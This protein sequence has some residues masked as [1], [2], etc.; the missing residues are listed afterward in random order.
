MSTP[1]IAPWRASAEVDSTTTVGRRDDIDG[2]RALA[3]LL[4]VVY[5]VWLGRVSGGVDVFLMLSAFFLTL[6]FTRRL[7]SGNPLGI[8]R[9]WIR[10]FKRLL[11]A[12]VVV[13]VAVLA[14]TALLL[15]PT[16]WPT[17]WQQ[18]WTSLF[19]VQNWQLAAT[20]VDYYAPHGALVSP[21]QHFWSLSV[22]GQ[23]FILWPLI[24]VLAGA[25][26]R[27]SGRQVRTVLAVLFG[28]V[29]IVSLASSVAETA[30]AQ[31]FA[32]FDTGARLWEF[33][34]GSLV[35]L[36]L[37]FVNL[38][39][40]ARVA[41]GWGGI[42]A[43]FMCGLVLD[44]RGGFPGF[45]ALWP[46]LAC[47]AVVLGG[48]RPT[49]Y[50]P[51]RLL[52]SPPLR[53]LGTWSY[54]LYLVHWPV[55]IFWFAITGRNSAGLLSGMAII[56]V[57][58]CLAYLVH[59]L[60]EQPVR[61][62][63]WADVTPRRGVAVIVAAVLVVAVPLTYWQANE[64]QRA[65]E[66]S[67]IGDHP[68]AEVL[69]GGF[70][71]GFA[72]STPAVPLATALDAEWIALDGPCTGAFVPED[73]ELEGSCTQSIGAPSDA[74]TIVVV[75]DSHAEQ[76]MG[77]L[78]PITEEEEWQVVAL[79]KGGCP[80]AV[81]EGKC[82]VWS[83]A[84]LRY[85]VEL[86]PEAVFTIGTAAEI[87]GSGEQL[88]PGIMRVLDE[89]TDAGIDV[90]AVRDN[91]RYSVNRYECA[92]ANGPDHSAC[93]VAVSDALADPSPLDDVAW[94]S[95]VHPVDLTP[96]I[97]PDDVCIAVVGNVYVYLDDNHLTGTYATSLAP[98]LRESIDGVIF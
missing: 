46:T 62:W 83:E 40:W 47:A 10:T 21:L 68:G 90:I 51:G 61:A 84:A 71:D 65:E 3:V 1:T 14:A 72:A 70:P 22:Q 66:L 91:P 26:V 50:G 55:L 63:R 56:A 82:S 29:M 34:L 4:V 38:P 78:L 9:Y 98:M 94:M 59:R 17:I 15:P 97:C 31:D 54:A 30:L 45:L 11:P 37:P 24:F 6:S 77:A 42:A 20:A 16:Q 87:D 88:V 13:L 74:P 32:Y 69:A 60:V 58:I 33:A 76:F 49:R 53:R 85:V 44:V 35:A 64:Q 23:V 28:A 2:L 81:D 18:S 8:G 52:A 36:A 73:P 95:G 48:T 86:A 25:V 41:L 7:E 93:Q 57:S 79:L 43:L 27:R 89:I 92:L 19:Y 96:Y 80:F 67:R 5:H 39:D 12:S 75:G